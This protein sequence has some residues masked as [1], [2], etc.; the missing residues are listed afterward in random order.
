MISSGVA[1]I[2]VEALG[3]SITIADGSIAIE[4]TK[5]ELPAAPCQRQKARPP[6]AA[7]KGWFVGTLVG[8]ARRFQKIS[9]KPDL[10]KRTRSIPDPQEIPVRSSPK[11]VQPSSLPAVAATYGEPKSGRPNK[12]ATGLEQPYRT[13]RRFR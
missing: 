11:P 7:N 1:S 10:R 13:S 5:T 9:V 12:T 4:Q 3:I 8:D 2:R 6:Q